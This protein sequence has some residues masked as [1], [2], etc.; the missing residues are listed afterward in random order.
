MKRSTMAM[1][2][3]GGLFATAVAANVAYN[4]GTE[5]EVCFT[6]T[7]RERIV[8]T[9]SDGQISSK[10]LVFTDEGTFENTDSLLR[11]KFR[12]SDHQGFLQEGQSYNATVY[13][14]RIGVF[15]SYPNIVDAQPVASCE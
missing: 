1:T 15:S 4:Y 6:V 7:D 5:R 8:E 9:D 13:G 14:W 3:I 2:A 11:G 10:Y 12:S